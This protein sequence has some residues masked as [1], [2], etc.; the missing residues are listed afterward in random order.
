MRKFPCGFGHD[1]IWVIRGENPWF[2]S[3]NEAIAWDMKHNPELH[4]TK[5]LSFERQEKSI[6]PAHWYGLTREQRKQGVQLCDAVNASER[7]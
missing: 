4:S 6:Y 2:T 5:E 7:R 1:V 3:L